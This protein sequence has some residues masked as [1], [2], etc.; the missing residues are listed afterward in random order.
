V[1]LQKKKLLRKVSYSINNAD[2]S[3]MIGRTFKEQSYLAPGSP[4]EYLLVR[5]ELKTSN[6]AVEV[7]FSEAII[8]SPNRWRLFSFLIKS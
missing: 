8:S 3:N 6:T 7:K 1:T 5:H 2:G 4:S